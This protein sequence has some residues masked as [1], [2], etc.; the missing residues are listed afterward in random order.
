MIEQNNKENVSSDPGRIL[1]VTLCSFLAAILISLTTPAESATEGITDPIK[2]RHQES[3]GLPT[4]PTSNGYQEGGEGRIVIN[5]A[6][7]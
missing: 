7:Q 2:R 6:I 1:N 4:I 5:V 3:S